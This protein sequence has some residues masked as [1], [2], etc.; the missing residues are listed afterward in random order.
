ME[1]TAG[2]SLRGT[3]DT[4][5]SVSEG[6]PGDEPGASEGHIP[7]PEASDVLR[8]SAASAPTVDAPRVR[9]ARPRPA[10]SKAML[11]GFVGESWRVMTLVWQCLRSALLLV[12]PENLLE[13]L[14]AFVRDLGRAR[15]RS[16]P[17]Q[18]DVFQAELS[19]GDE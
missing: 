16:R 5:L 1:S 14:P 2:L 6:S 15:E 13:A 17:K 3:G 9:V 8:P 4:R 12:R 7:R 18:I 10:E 11:A 19:N